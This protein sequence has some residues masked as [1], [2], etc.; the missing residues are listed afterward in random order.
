MQKIDPLIKE[1]LGFEAGINDR[2]FLKAIRKTKS[3]VCKPCWEIKYCPYGP[4]IEE[5][6]LLPL[7]LEIANQHLEYAKDCLKNGQLGDGTPLDKKKREMFGNEIASFSE[8]QYV[9]KIPSEVT[10][11]SCTEFGH[12]CPVFFVSEEFTETS[13]QRRRGRYIPF[14]IK[15]RVVRRDNYTCQ[16]CGKH[17]LDDEVEFDHIIPLSKGGSSEEQNIRLTCFDCNRDKSDTLE[18]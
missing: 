10:E 7:T 1:A 6:P 5:F 14:G 9:Q 8:D 11:M 2:D 16:I 18:I 15:M 3:L 13:E 17:L 4:F 12:I